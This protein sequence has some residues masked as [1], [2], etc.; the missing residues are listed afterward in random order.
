MKAKKLTALLVILLI[1]SLALVACTG[2]TPEAPTDDTSGPGKDTPT[3]EV[4]GP[5]TEVTEE[6]PHTMEEVVSYGYST[7]DIPTLDPQRGEDTVSITYIE[8]LFVHLTNYDLDT[9]EVVPEAA[10]SW[11][12]SED[13]L[14]YTFA[15]RTDIPWVNY[16]PVSGETTQ[17]V[18]EEGNPRFVTAYDFEYG[19]KRACDPELGSYYSTVVAPQLKGCGAVLFADDPDAVTEEDYDAIGVTATDEGT[20][21]IELEFPASFFLS[22]TP[23]WT[24]AATPQW[25]IEENGD[26][27]TEAGLIVT[28]GRYALAEWVH[29]VRRIAVRNPLMPADMAGD[30]NID[31][32]V[33]DVVPDGST[34][35]ALWL[36][37]D[38]EGSGI[39]DAELQAHLDNYPDETDQIADL[40]VFYFD[41]AH[42]KEPFNNVHVRR[43]FSAA[44]DRQ[45]FIDTVRQGQG[46]PMK[47][48]A[49]PGIFGAPPIDE[50]G[51]GF[52]PVW[53]KEQLAEAGYPDCEGFPNV[54]LMG[55][56]G[57]S[58]LNWIEYAQA[59]WSENL[60]C[61]AE[62][63]SI[64]QLSFSELLAAT[65]PDAPNRPHM[66]T[67]G[68]GPDYADENNWVGD[69]IWCEADDRRVREC[70]ET[71]DLIVQAREESD[72]AVREELYR[73]IEE[74]F[75]GYEGEF[76][77]APLFVRIAFVANHSWLDRVPALFGGDQWYTWNLDV[78]A[79]AAYK[80]E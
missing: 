45:T 34:G 38:V 23:I 6:P 63:I 37:G 56:S 32:F 14:T 80:G 57:Q 28:N 8:N 21:V 31:K 29:G 5:G 22:M 78:E 60:G 62:L 9:A 33:I 16:N 4:E 44:F 11:D 27:W 17:E 49:P 15:I 70:T 65:K 71:D 13:G 48:F 20:L 42:E 69:V 79:R 47:H 40:A 26:Q 58:T 54:T 46:L 75:F 66:W 1:A 30:G 43:A 2:S 77:M 10:T 61:S 52:D 3:E 73:Q 24:M 41:F 35:Y 7:T 67:L 50:V 39:P 18:D 19:I 74:N 51:V 68:W 59:N 25:A 55:Y 72:P 12:I 53:A 36:D 76:P 64:E